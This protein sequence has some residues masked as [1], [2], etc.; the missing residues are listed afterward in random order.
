[1]VKEVGNILNT[2][3]GK[4]PLEG[5][6]MIDILQRLSI[7]Y[8]FREE[9]EAL[10]ETEYMNFKAPNHHHDDVY[11]VA[12]SFR[13]LRQHGYNVSQGR[14][15]KKGPMSKGGPGHGNVFNSFK[16]KEGK[17][18][19]VLRDDLKGLMALYEASQLSMESENILDEAGDF[20]AKLL[21]HHESEIVANTLKSPYHKSLARLTVENF[22]NNIDSRSEYIKVFS[23]LAKMDYEIVRFIH[24]KEILRITKWDLAAANQLP[25]SMKISL[26]A[27][28]DITEDISTQWK[29]LCNAFLVEAKWFAL[30]K[31][32]K[33]EEYLRNG[34]VSS[35]VHVVLVHMFFLLGQGINKE[36]VDFVDGIPAII[37]YTAMILR[38]WDDLGTAKDENQDGRDGSYL[39]C[40]IREHPNITHERAREHVSQLIC[41]AWKQLNREC[42]SRPSSFSATFTEAC[43]NVAR[44]VPLMYSYDDNPSLPSLKEHMK[45]LAGHLESK[46]SVG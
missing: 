12:L 13:L 23:E 40:Y 18:D 15:V 17:F 20:S 3:A 44:M 28:F 11:G 27:L 33:A 26:K 5:L 19:M 39:E 42:L 43:L 38:L 8:H 30:G 7:D 2:V 29:K 16:N 45:S 14:R 4:D 32:P 25:E 46:P 41:D 34:I 21:N 36:T 9:I 10:L 24:Q 37:S 1:M 6:A 31:L 22:L 35:G